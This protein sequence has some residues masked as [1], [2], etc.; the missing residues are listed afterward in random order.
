MLIWKPSLPK[1]NFRMTQVMQ[2]P[3]AIHNYIRK[4]RLKYL[5][6]LHTLFPCLAKKK[7]E[8]SRKGLYLSGHCI[9]CTCVLAIIILC[10]YLNLLLVMEKW[11]LHVDFLASPSSYNYESRR[12]L[13]NLS[14][15]KITVW[16]ALS[17][18]Y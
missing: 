1:Y 3:P 16:K 9:V 8:V 6:V 13:H 4:V 17:T 5:H 7:A 10:M 11:L 14:H 18:F 2:W 12:P 15:S